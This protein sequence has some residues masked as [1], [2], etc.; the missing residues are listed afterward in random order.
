MSMSVLKSQVNYA[1]WLQCI[2]VTAGCYFFILSLEIQGGLIERE[3]KGV[4]V[5]GGV[6]GGISIGKC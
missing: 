2:I 5:G 1:Y 6:P 4:G 3:R